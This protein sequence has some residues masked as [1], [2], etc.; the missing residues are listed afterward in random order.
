M[1]TWFFAFASL[2][3]S[4]I[5]PAAD[6]SMHAEFRW[7]VVINAQGSITSITP[8]PY[9]NINQ[10]KQI[11]RRL[12]AEAKTFQFAPGT[13]DGKPAE[14]RTGLHLSTTLLRVGPDKVNIR[15]DCAGAGASLLQA[16]F[17][18]FP[19]DA[20]RAQKGGYVVLRIAYNANGAISSIATDPRSHDATPALIDASEKAVR[21]WRIIPDTVGG[22][23]LPGEAFAPFCY[24]F[25]A[26]D[27]KACTGLPAC[28]DD[29]LPD[30]ATTTV[31]GAK[32]LTD[33]A[34]RTL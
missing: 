16:R 33:V 30:S 26:H 4:G 5:A 12:E 29:T 8:A 7:R 6:T 15:L 22:Q 28:S 32:L 24:R 3:L 2:A 14:T 19:A 11:R 23:P 20:I 34:G 27:A 17:P 9:E 31:H 13:V 10:L 1:R 18:R 25:D 21:E